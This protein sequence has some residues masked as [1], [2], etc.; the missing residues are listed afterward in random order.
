MNKPMP[1]H[2]ELW[3]AE[4]EKVDVWAAGAEVRGLLGNGF[5][6]PSAPKP[7]KPRGQRGE[8]TAR[9]LIRKNSVLFLRVS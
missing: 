1:E 4:A 2:L 8:E 7:P 6:N 9:W 5:L 3:C